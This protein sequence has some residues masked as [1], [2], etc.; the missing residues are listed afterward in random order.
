MSSI[1]WKLSVAFDQKVTI[2]VDVQSV[3]MFLPVMKLIT[4][5]SSFL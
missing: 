5:N 4:D 3:S 1:L 2:F